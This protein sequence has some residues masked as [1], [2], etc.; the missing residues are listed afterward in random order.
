MPIYDYICP[1]CEATSGHLFSF[2]EYDAIDTVD[3]PDCGTPMDKD[4]REYQGITK[5]IIGVS[6]GNY[7]GRDYT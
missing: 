3:C 5:R 1:K 6:K 2:S 7:N 4:D